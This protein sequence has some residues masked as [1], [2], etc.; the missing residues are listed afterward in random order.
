MLYR[1][2]AAL[3]AA[4]DQRLRNKSQESGVSVERLRRRV[5]YERIVV[6]LDLAEPGMW[7]VKGGLALD[8]RLGRRARAS[9]DLDLGL[10]EDAIEGDRLRDRII[11]AL[12]SDPDD[13]WFTFVVGRAE[14]LQADRGG[15]AIWRYSVQADLAGKQFGSLRLDVAPRVEELEP[16]ER[17]SLHNE[18]AFARVRSRTVELID[19]DRHAAEK[20]HA[21]TRT[22]HNQPSTRVR[23]LVDLVLLLENDYLDDDGCRAAIRTTFQQRGTHDLP[24]D[25]SEPPPAWTDTYSSLVAALDVEADS[26]PE[27]FDLVRSWWMRL[28]LRES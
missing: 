22:Y 27:A 7:V 28:G 20:L 13:D 4:L 14:Q 1:S 10:R 11:E 8:V 12:E 18:L 26:L 17:L 3:R 15:R 2:P 16:T 23:D 24:S 9:M 6:R 19:I 5:M 21:L 25:L